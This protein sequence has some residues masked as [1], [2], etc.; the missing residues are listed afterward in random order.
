MYNYENI[1]MVTQPENFRT[2]LFRHQLASIYN[3]EKLE[4]EQV[5]TI[6]ENTKMKTNIGI[7]AD[8]TGYGKC[9]KFDTPVVLYNGK[10]EKVQNIKVG[11]MLMG[12]D[13]TPREVLTLARGRENMYTIKQNKGGDDY[14]VNESH[15]LSLKMSC[16]K[17]MTDNK[18]KQQFQVYCF[19]NQI[20]KFTVKLFNYSEADKK[21]IRKHARNFSNSTEIDSRVDISVKNYLRLPT[22]IRRNLMGY[23]VSVEFPEQSVDMDPYMLGLWLGEHT[24]TLKWKKTIVDTLRKYNLVDNKHIPHIYLTNSRSVRLSL[25]AGIV[26][27]IGHYS[28]GMYEISQT[29]QKL[30]NGI[31]YL[32]R[33]LGLCAQISK[34]TKPRVY[35][36]ITIISS[37]ILSDTRYQM[38][39]NIQI[40]PQGE[41][42][43]YGFTINGNHRFLLGD[44]TVTHNTSSIIGLIIRDKFQWDVDTSYDELCIST[45]AEDHIKNYTTYQ[46]DKLPTTL[47]LAPSTIISQWKQE[48]SKSDLVYTSVIEKNDVDS[49]NPVDYD[50]VLVTPYMYNLLI[51]SNSGLAWKRFIYDEPGHIRVQSMKPVVSGF[52]WLVTATPE[53]ILPLHKMSRNSFMYKIIGGKKPYCHETTFRPITIKNDLEFVTN[54]FKMP[55]THHHY[56]KCFQPVA[57]SV[58]GFVKDIVNTMIE[59]G[60]IEGAIISLGGNKTDNII[61]LVKQ[62]KQEEIEFIEAEIK[63]SE[64]RKNN[65]RILEWGKKKTSVEQQIKELDKRFSDRLKKS[66]AICMEKMESPV[67]EPNCQN[68]FCGECL[69]TWL[70][71]KMNCPLCRSHVDT[72][73]LT[74]VETETEKKIKS[75]FSPSREKTK[76]ETIIDILQNKDGK[77]IIFSNFDN[78]FNIIQKILQENSI[79]YAQIK[80]TLKSIDENLKKYKEGELQV[81]FLNS[82]YNG[83][84]LNLQE[85]TD[86]IIYHEMPDATM[87]Q[88]LGRAQR[89]G[90]VSDL[91]VHYLQVSGN[92]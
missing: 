82:K 4:R 73:K 36:R 26:G 72:T 64:I 75:C 50:V 85:T 55:P 20:V 49:T 39:T 40:I 81:I 9:L 54:S 10:I 1:N 92:M 76:E 78:T 8:L 65:K 66:C 12:D 27:S 89:I 19:D 3:M 90:R 38:C 15:I 51:M 45:Q 43:Y 33:S 74:Y 53:A 62:R 46:H 35:N 16:C 41:G 13:S 77:F 25:L 37:Y 83:S 21:E 84:G 87:T 17:Y 48:L 79:K 63:I 58:R 61:S 56:H 23:R 68:L 57:N 32:A 52:K 6:D 34:V 18:T 7:L 42:D 88:I 70:Q 69:L 30:T 22:W 5:V 86:I 28:K 14:T 2:N 29:S 91:H 60:D 31:V 80:G 71:K 44:F 47:I 67:L 24:S 11:D 59:A